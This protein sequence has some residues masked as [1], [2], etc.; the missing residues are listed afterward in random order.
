[1]FAFSYPGF[2][3]RMELG[4]KDVR[5]KTLEVSRTEPLEHVNAFVEAAS[6]IFGWLTIQP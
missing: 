2:E 3:V 5:Y 4:R 1:M 6:T